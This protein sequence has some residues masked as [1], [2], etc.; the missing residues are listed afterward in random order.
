[1]EI[2]WDGH[3]KYTYQ[4]KPCKFKNYLRKL[5]FLLK[6]EFCQNNNI[7]FGIM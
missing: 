2:A 1:M 6:E 3:Y 5:L 7:Q 4:K